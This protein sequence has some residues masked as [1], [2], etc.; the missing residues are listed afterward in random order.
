VVHTR[1][2]ITFDDVRAA[3]DRLTG[4]A[5][6]TPVLTSATLDER[7]GAHVFLKAENFQRMGAFKFRGAYNR[8][9]QL[10]PEERRGGVIAFSS[11][12]HAQG[13]ALACK[14]LGVP[15]LIVMPND[16]PELKV[17]ATEGYGAE[18]VRYD[19]YTEDRVAIAKRLAGERGATVVPP[20]DDAHIVAGQGT[21]ALELL[22]DA[23]S[24]DIIVCA[25]GGGGLLAGTAIAAHGIDPNIQVFG[26]EPEAGDDFKRSLEKG[27]RIHIDVP[28]TIADGQQTQSP[29][30]I[31]FRIA[32]EERVQVV[33]VSDDQI[34]EAMRFAFDRLKIVIE[35][36]GATSLAAV[37]CGGIPVTGKR[38]GVIISGGNV[39]AKRFAELIS[40]L[41]S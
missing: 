20:F 30:E 17:A 6:R 41:S 12:N 13:V 26:V 21:A 27:E 40:P 19:R 36:S 33:T 38:A 3:A 4:V 15:A 10:T 22:Q 9:S 14:L 34:R 35:P 25:V 1:S 7:T 23:G 16:A 2:Q 18:V 11:G 28:R 39:D 5:H 32:R 37:L 29:G 8:I 24:L 31:T